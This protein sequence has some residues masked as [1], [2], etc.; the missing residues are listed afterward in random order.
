MTVG[1]FNATGDPHRWRETAKSLLRSAR[2]GEQQ[3]RANESHARGGEGI[4]RD[5]G[6]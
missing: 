6:V 3:H 5:A 4:R 1:N 2:S